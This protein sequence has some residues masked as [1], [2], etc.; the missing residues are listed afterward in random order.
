MD[1]FLGIHSLPKLT[2]L[3]LNRPISINEIEKLSKELLHKKASGPDG[4]IGEFCQT[5]RE[6]SV[7]KPEK[8][9]QRTEKE[10]KL[11]HGFSKANYNIDCTQKVMDYFHS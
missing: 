10:K 8:L 2:P 7:P 11:P 9:F 6:Q 4:F 3:E 5:V 1:N